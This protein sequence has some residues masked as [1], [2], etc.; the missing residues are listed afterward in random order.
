MVLLAK[1]APQGF[2][3]PRSQKNYTTPPSQPTVGLK[4]RLNFDASELETVKTFKLTHSVDTNSSDDYFPE[5]SEAAPSPYVPKRTSK[6]APQ[7]T[8]ESL[9]AN[10]VIDDAAARPSFT[11]KIRPIPL[12]QADVR[13]PS[14]LPR[15]L[16][17]FN[18]AFCWCYF[19]MLL[20][21]VLS[22]V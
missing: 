14:F 13:L 8:S 5:G 19:L 3:S 17:L 2:L 15:P 7:K 9:F 21:L 10:V 22:S 18:L 16:A 12:P 1:E 20:V 11:V 6:L 4:R